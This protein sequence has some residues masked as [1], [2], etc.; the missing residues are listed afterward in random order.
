M[1]ATSVGQIGLDLVVNQNQ[2]KQQMSGIGS[3]AKKAGAKLAAA[4]AV[5]KLVEFGKECI[6]LGSNLAEVQNVVDVTF[7]R[8]TAQVDKFAKSAAQSFGLSETMAKKFTGTFGAMAKAF[9]FSEKQAY[10][11]STTLTGLAGDVASFYNLTQDEAYTK[12]KSVFTGETETLKDLGVV[13][14]QNALDAYA[15]ANGYGKVTAKMTE[16]EKVALRYAFVQDQLAAATGDF[17]RTSD[18]WANQTRILKLQFDSLK[19]TIGQG[20]INLFTPILKVIN[21]L[22]GKLSTLADA[23]KSFTELIT[24]NKA[25]AGSGISGMADIADTSLSNAADSAGALADNTSGVGAAAKKAAKEMK[26]LMGFDVVSKLAEPADTS[27]DTAPSGGSGTGGIAGGTVDFGSLAQGET[28]LEKTDSKFQG[29]ID[30]CKELSDLF[31]KGFEIGFGDSDKKIDSLKEHISGIGQSLKDIFTDSEVVAAADRLFDSISENAGKVIGSMANIGLTIADNLVGGIDKYLKKSKD[32]IKNRLVSMFDA[33]AD[34]HG[35]VGDFTAAFADIFD[36]FRGENAKSCTASIIGIF[37]DGFLGAIDLAIQFGRDIIDVITTPIVNNK[38]RF[39]IAIN[40]ML[41]PISKELDTLHQAVKNTFSKCQEVYDEHIRPMLQSFRDGISDLVG[42]LLDSYNTYIAPVLDNLADKFTTVWEDHIQ[43]ATNAIMDVV[44]KVSDMF[45]ALWENVLMPLASWIIDTIMPILAP[46]F[47]SLGDTVLKVLSGIWDAV[48]NL[49][50]VLG[51]LIDFLTG[52]FSGDWKKAWEGIKSIFSGIW[53]LIKGIISTAWDAIKGIVQTAIN[54][55]KGIISTVLN[56]IKS[57]FTT[58]WNGIK[59]TVTTVWNGLKN[60]ASTVFNG[61]KNIISTIW[62]G[63]KSVTSNMWNSIKSVVT[64]AWNGLKSS[65][66][67]IFG[68]IKSVISNAWNG[69]KSTATNIWNGISTAVGD[70]W[71]G[72]TDTAKDALNGIKDAFKSIF[73]SIKNVIKTPIN[74][75]IKVINGLISG[76]VSGVNGVIGVLNKLSVKIPSWVPMFGGKT[77]GFNI[78]KVTAP[79]I[80]MLAQGGYVKPNTP[81]LAMIGDNRHQGEVVAPEDKLREMAMEAVKAAG[82]NGITR[83]ELERIINN[84]VMRIVAALAGMGFYLDGDQLAKAMQSAAQSM[85]TRFNP[86]EVIL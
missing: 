10:D 49:M 16:A 77:F 26:G 42:K 80:P 19:A 81:Q 45:K 64:G 33:T 32:F 75:I 65:A 60:A 38:D 70:I 13:M 71:N 78:R 62:N 24:G 50:T 67:S 55:V 20:L 56:A 69:V 8:M 73:T 76:V 27:S 84:A 3:L 29:L 82:S 1:A 51:G 23:F 34:I 36:V 47:E 79:Q 6:E 15:M 48:K 31:K 30:R 40:N 53:D 59:N 22:L 35:L 28:V 9:G 21:T 2:F 54:V 5:K 17:A 39:K 68:G 41:S 74:A 25:S 72:M 11:M 4:F 85:D 61:I 44:G 12:L 66:S 63:L 14:T 46:I 18:S 37:S 7:P 43:P 58:V 52:V 57:L 86:V 83:D